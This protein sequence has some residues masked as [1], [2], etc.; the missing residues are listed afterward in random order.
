MRRSLF[1]YTEPCLYVVLEN[2][3]NAENR[4]YILRRKPNGGRR[5]VL[6]PSL[7]GMPR[8]ARFVAVDS[9]I[10]VFGGFN[11]HGKT[12]GALS[13]DC[14]SRYHTVQPLPSMPVPVAT[15][16]AGIIDEKI[17]VY[18]DTNYNSKVTVVFNTETQTWEQPRTIEPDIKL[19][20]ELY[21]CVVKAN[22]LYVRDAH[23]KSF[24]YEPK[25]NTWEETEWSRNEK[26]NNVSVV[27]DKCYYYDRR[28]NQLMAYDTE[29]RDW[30]VVRG[31]DELLAEMERSVGLAYT[32]SY[33]GKLLLLFQRKKSFGVL[34]L[35]SKHAITIGVKLC[36]A[37]LC[38]LGIFT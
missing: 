15:S 23:N 4:V 19:D 8:E 13:I 37:M 12:S 7:P 27:D 31:V 14:S 32:V 22:K 25:E 30:R 38:L 20:H 18:G 9:K 11:H 10:H 21:G 16:V 2:I 1:D 3:E 34:R 6:I 5:L 24:V 29:K 28:R 36:G 33:G 35:R 26:W 17:Y